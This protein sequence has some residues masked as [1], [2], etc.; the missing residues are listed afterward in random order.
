MVSGFGPVGTNPSGMVIAADRNRGDLEQQ[1]E[2]LRSNVQTMV[3]SFGVLVSSTAHLAVEVQRLV[4]SPNA[5]ERNPQGASSPEAAAQSEKT[6][7]GA[8]LGRTLDSTLA[9]VSS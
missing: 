5:A 6:P 7:S 8:A 2:L 3:D 9:Q 1:V 4:R